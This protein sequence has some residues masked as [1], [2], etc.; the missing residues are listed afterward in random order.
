VALNQ[1]LVA[2]FG[3][4]GRFVSVILVVLAAAASI[5]SALPAVFDTVQPLLPL[6]PA[7]EGF[8]SITTAAGGT[9]ASAGLLFAWL[10]VGVAASILAVARRRVAAPLGAVV[11]A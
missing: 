10:I 11:P 8:R 5:T 9:G 7:L 2:W 6:T 1:A 3:G 4:V